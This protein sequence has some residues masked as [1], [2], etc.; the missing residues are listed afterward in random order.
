MQHHFF[1]FI[2]IYLALWCGFLYC[3]KSVVYF[4]G[5]FLSNQLVRGI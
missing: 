1:V 4:Y 2:F 3:V 5:H